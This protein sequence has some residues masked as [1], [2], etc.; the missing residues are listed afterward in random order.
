LP[1]AGRPA[2][3]KLSARVADMLAQ[4]RGRR[5]GRTRPT[6]RN[7]QPKVG[8]PPKATESPRKIGEGSTV[9]D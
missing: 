8:S 7:H 4:A 1:E 9:K 2:W 6:R 5:P 3:Q